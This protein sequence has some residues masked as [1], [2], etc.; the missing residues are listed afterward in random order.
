M[1]RRFR[2]SLA[3]PPSSRASVL[4]APS[5]SRAHPYSTEPTGSWQFAVR[6]VGAVVVALGDRGHA[7]DGVEDADAHAIQRFCGGADLIPA[8]LR[9]NVLPTDRIVRIDPAT[10]VVTATIDASGLLRSDEAV[11]GSTLNGI[12][13]VPGMNQFLVTGKFWP[14]MACVALISA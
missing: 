10:G 3:P 5:I 9:A 11:P 6:P 1:D 7:E 2:R 13:A 14:R 12:A 4:T 8:G